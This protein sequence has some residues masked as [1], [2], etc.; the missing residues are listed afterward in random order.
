[1]HIS[2]TI[3][4]TPK[5]QKR[6]RITARGGYARSYKDKS[7][8]LYE[9]KVKALIDQYK[10]ERPYEGALV[11]YVE[12]GL[13]IPKSWSKKKRAAALEGEIAATCKPD[14]LNIAKNIED[15]MNGIFYLDDKQI[16]R[17]CII[18][19]YSDNPQW[20][21]ELESLEVNDA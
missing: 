18:K 11:L 13:P 4:I 8:V 5:A 16:V 9:A 6:D 12:I 1:M 2:F 3:P 15:I 17:H 20:D 10:P 14:N 21:I 7:Q 19:Y